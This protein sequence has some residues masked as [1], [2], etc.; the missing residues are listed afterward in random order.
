MAT[1]DASLPQY[2]D[3]GGYSEQ[4]GNGKLE[5]EMDSGIRQMRNLFT[6]VPTHFSIVLTLTNAQVDTLYT[7][8]ETTCK[9]GTLEFTWVHPRSH[10]SAD[11]RFIGAPPVVTYKNYDAFIARFNVEVLPA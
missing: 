3:A 8:Y 6:A 4:R 1:W 2:P 10:A 7:F 5:T 9:N 11:M